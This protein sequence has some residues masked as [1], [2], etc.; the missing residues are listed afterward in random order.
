[1]GVLGFPD[2][3]APLHA[4]RAVV[5]GWT[6]GPALDDAEVGAGIDECRR[7]AYGAGVELWLLGW[8]R[9]HLAH[10]DPSAAWAI[11]QRLPVDL[12]STDGFVLA[13]LLETAHRV[14]ADAAPYHAALRTRSL[15][16]ASPGGAALH[17]WSNAHVAG[18]DTA[19]RE[20]ILAFD[21][22]RAPMFLARSH[23]A[24]G[25]RMRRGRRRAEA[26]VHLR[27]AA[28]LFAAEGADGWAQRANR[29]LAA[30]GVA[31]R[32]TT[33]HLS[34]LTPQEATVA[35]LA[36]EGATNSVIAERLYLSPSTVDYHLRKV[37]RKLEVTS[38]RQLQAALGPPN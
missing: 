5:R 1:M 35:R 11:A 19:W 3:Y 29:E 14:G 31:T 16:V 23:L 8:M 4:M 20:C 22:A 9:Q 36:A 6:S 12:A 10:G 32:Q 26:L 13:D 18:T 7:L 33:Q 38:R 34:G 25:E 21:R 30:L 28:A 24:L 2:D 15:R 27:T 17:A 37:F